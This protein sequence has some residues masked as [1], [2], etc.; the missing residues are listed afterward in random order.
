MDR[1]R[2]T[3]SALACLL[4]LANCAA[5][6]QQEAHRDPQAKSTSKEW[7]LHDQRFED[8]PVL[9][10]SVT[11]VIDGDTIDVLL[12]SGPIRVRFSSSD[13]PERD[14]RWGSEATAALSRRIAGQQVTL[15]P[16]AQDRY[17]R[18][19]AFVYLQDEDLN[20]WMVR[21]GHAWAYREYLEDE[22]SCSWEA[23]A[24][25]AR[26]GLWAPEQAPA[27]APWEWRAPRQ[28]FTDYRG[29]TVA[30]CLATAGKRP[31]QLLASTAP[32]S[33]PSPQRPASG[34]LIKGNI[35]K[36]GRIYHMPRSP[37]Y[38]STIIDKSTGE[39]WFCTEQEAQAAGWRA[40]Q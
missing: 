15:V 3:A 24:R 26:R 23:G 19:V 13:A 31:S 37:S 32:G 20:A 28:T 17:D 22:W 27:Y 16:V 34:C 8:N 11:K 40:P 38:D 29:E 35:S 36:N 12:S 7:V 10:G 21:Q 2:S 1:L 33:S 4:A 14:Q 30:N 6:P 9:V 25:D 18:L 39:R 5:L